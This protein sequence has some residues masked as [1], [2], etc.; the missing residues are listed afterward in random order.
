MS[1]ALTAYVFY[2]GSA[3]VLLV[4]RRD[5][6][7][8][9]LGP[10]S[11]F[12]HITAVALP[13]AWLYLVPVNEGQGR[14]L[15]V[16]MLAKLAPAS[17]TSYAGKLIAYP[18]ETIL[19]LAPVAFIAGYCWWKGARER[20]EAL[21]RHTR[22]AGWIALVGYL[23]YWLAPQSSV[24]YLLPLY[25]LIG[26]I[27]ARAI[28]SAGE[29]GLH[30]TWRWLV[31]AIALKLVVML[32]VFPWYQNSYRGKNYADAARD[33]QRMTEGHVFYSNVTTASG[34]SVT[35]HLDILRLPRPPLTFPPAQWETGFVLARVPDPDL[36]QTVAQ[37][38]FGG[39]AL[40]LLCRG[41]ACAPARK[42]GS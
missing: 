41:D 12:I 7:T 26:L 29:Q 3:L 24:R 8:F 34:L 11:W 18:V 6:R 37:Y 9:L 38:S 30:L 35:A 22:I 10:G 33:I 25:P 14:R 15:F 20:D 5:Y 28:W 16:E 27:L 31:A 21:A 40:Y 4:A 17:W 13:L 39:D 42:D 23:P 36:G 19:R 32:A 1:K 2:G